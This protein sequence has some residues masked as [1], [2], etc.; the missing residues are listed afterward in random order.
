MRDIFYR[1]ICVD[2][3][4]WV[5]GGIFPGVD[6]TL[7]IETY[8][9]SPFG[10]PNKHT[11]EVSCIAH[12][13]NP[14]TVGQ[15]TGLDD[16]N[17]KPIFEGDIILTQPFY[18]RRNHGKRKSKRFLAV[19]EYRAHVGHNFFNAETHEYDKSYSVSAEFRARLLE[20][21]SKTPYNYSHWGDFFQCEVVGNIYDNPELLSPNT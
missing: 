7:I 16:V 6:H 19:V 3:G 2:T 21:I 1:G 18:T 12:V 14:E 10:V 11:G 8:R 5:T 15:Y 4:K 9:V 20:D 17:G 13:V